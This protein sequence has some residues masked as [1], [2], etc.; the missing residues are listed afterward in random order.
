[1]AASRF[2]CYWHR[3]VHM[4]HEYSS[5]HRNT[6]KHKTPTAKRS[7]QAYSCSRS[8][9]TSMSHNTL[10]LDYASAELY[11]TC[12]EHPVIGRCAQLHP[13]PL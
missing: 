13:H 6:G 5:M 2:R 11:V 10:H 7:I 9:G 8:F 12:C 4:K 1:M 3:S